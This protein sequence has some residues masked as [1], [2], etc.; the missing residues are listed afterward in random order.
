MPASR[1]ARELGIAPNYLRQ[2]NREEMIPSEEL[3]LKIE[4]ATGGQ[5][6]VEELRGKK[7]GRRNE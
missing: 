5:V 2:I 3:A 1:F 7:H 4:I 6:T